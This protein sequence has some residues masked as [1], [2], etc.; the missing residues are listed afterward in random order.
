MKIKSF[1]VNPVM[2][3]TYVIYDDESLEAAIIDCGAFSEAEWNRIYSFIAEN[4]LIVTHLLC[5]HMHFDHIMGNTF[6]YRD[7]KLVP[8]CG[9]N[10]IALWKDF[11]EQIEM[12]FGAMATKL[13]QRCK[14]DNTPKALY[15][16]D[17]VKIGKYQFEVINT[18]GHTAGGICFYCESEGI[19]F[20]GDTL[21]NGSIGRTD[22]A[23]GD[24]RTL[25]ESITSRLF[26]L[27]ASTTVYCGHGE[28][29][30]ID[31]EMKYN[32]YL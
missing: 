1:V 2:E 8:E 17:T 32:P 13:I 20:A 27:P 28:P 3:N 30:T 31:N 19:L 18:P 26:S 4:K 25:I 29:T 22:L 11:D 12:F 5:T 10:D 23:G 14:T 9:V 21:F 24:Y 16:G 15:D 7:L 6:V